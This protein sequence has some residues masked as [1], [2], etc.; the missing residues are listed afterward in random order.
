[1]ATSVVVHQL[2]GSLTWS[3]RI[4]FLPHNQIGFGQCDGGFNLVKRRVVVTR[5][6]INL[7]AMA[8]QLIALGGD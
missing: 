4:N 8:D 1:M 5:N 6:R 2:L 3:I 7:A